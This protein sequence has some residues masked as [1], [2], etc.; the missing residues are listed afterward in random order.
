MDLAAQVTQFFEQYGATLP[1][2]SPLLVALSG[3][4][5]SL[6]LLHLLAV[7]GAAPAGIPLHAAH[8]D[9]ALRPESAAEAARVAAQC[10][11]WDVPCVRRAGQRRRPGQRRGAL[12]EEAGRR[13]RYTFFPP[14]SSRAG[15]RAIATGHNAG[16]QAETILHHLIRGSGLAGLRGMRP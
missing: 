4:P 10:A 11:A 12:L 14:P 7:A 3:G 1:P 8:L 16:D 5:D 6:V 2:R 9:H 15:R 13:A